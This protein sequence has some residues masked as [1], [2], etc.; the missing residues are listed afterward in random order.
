MSEQDNAADSTLSVEAELDTLR[1][2]VDDPMVLKAQLAKEAQARRALTAR[3]IKAEDKLKEERERRV[4]LESK[5][6][7]V[8]T[9]NQ[10]SP[11]TEAKPYEINDEIVDLRLDGYSKDEV[12]WILQN[13]GRKSLEDPNS[14][15]SIAIKTKREQTRAEQAASAVADTSQMSEIERRFT[16]EQLANM[17]VKELEKILPHA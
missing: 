14:F 5:Y 15:V 10:P 3:A 7:P 12:K 4:T 17:S 9:N 8:T 6:E 2:G 11:V 13:G 1:A 16:S